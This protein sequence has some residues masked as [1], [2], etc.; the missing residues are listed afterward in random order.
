MRHKQTPAFIAKAQPEPGAERTLYGDEV[1]P[2]FGLMVTATG[3]RGYVV[4]YRAKGKSRRM[5]IDGVLSLDKAK[6]AKY[7]WAK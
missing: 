4:Q 6:Q 5:T 7:Y 3:H 1:V 2:G